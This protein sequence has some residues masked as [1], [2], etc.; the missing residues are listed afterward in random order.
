MYNSPSPNGDHN[1]T[2]YNYNIKQYHRVYIHYLGILRAK[3]EGRSVAGYK[4][5]IIPPPNQTPIH[6]DVNAVKTPTPSRLA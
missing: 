5:A 6:P 3:L 1:P 2:D 4:K